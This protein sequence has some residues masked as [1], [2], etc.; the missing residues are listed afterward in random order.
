MVSIL[1][2]LAASVTPCL[3]DS[4]SIQER[5]AFFCCIPAI[6]FTSVP[7]ISYLR[8]PSLRTSW[9]RLI[10]LM[11]GCSIFGIANFLLVWI[12]TD[13]IC[14]IRGAMLQFGFLAS[15]FFVAA[16]LTYYLALD[17]HHKAHSRRAA[18]T[19]CPTPATP[20]DAKRFCQ[21]AIAICL[22]FPAAISLVLA[23]LDLYGYAGVWCWLAQSGA[24]FPAFYLWSPL[25][26]IYAVVSIVVL[27]ISERRDRSTLSPRW[28]GSVH[29][30]SSPRLSGT[31][32]MSVS[33]SASSSSPSLDSASLPTFLTPPASSGASPLS[34]VG[35]ADTVISPLALRAGLQVSEADLDRSRARAYRLQRLTARQAKMFDIHS[36]KRMKRAVT[37]YTMVAMIANTPAFI[38]RFLQQTGG[39]TAYVGLTML[40]AGIFRCVEPVMYSLIFSM[41]QELRVPRTLDEFIAQPIFAARLRDF[42]EKRMCSELLDAIIDIRRFRSRFAFVDG[43]SAIPPPPAM[44]AEASLIFDTFIRR[45]T[46]RQTNL[47]GH[48][49]QQ[50]AADLSA[51]AISASM[52]DVAEAQLYKVLSFDGWLS[53]V[54]S[55]A[56]AELK[57]TAVEE[58]MRF[59]L[60]WL[61]QRDKSGLGLGKTSQ[62]Q[63]SLKTTGSRGR[64]ASNLRSNSRPHR[65]TSVAGVPMHPRSSPATA[66]RQQ[67]FGL[68]APASPKSLVPSSHAPVV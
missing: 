43:S 12:R 24:W 27:S 64:A 9:S 13:S 50:V 14:K 32:S 45:G 34:A 6:L 22:G 61:L 42:L 10:V 11:L 67:T 20:F 53:Y 36:T 46:A 7:F 55:P 1:D 65:A 41:T 5:V 15:Y 2:R 35:P 18:S 58:G 26:T 60:R 8:I 19:T 51:G 56:Y 57:L 29:R 40:L 39:S 62:T 37:T 23:V 49:V 59:S 52:F 31:A 68:R 54:S 30:M 4:P 17:H 33:V 16:V 25:I 3:P 63:S 66:S 28:P 48:V 47:D 21:V 38:A 44:V